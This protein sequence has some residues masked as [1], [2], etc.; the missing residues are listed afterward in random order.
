MLGNEIERVAYVRTGRSLELL[1]IGWNSLEA[2]IA[3]VAGIVAGS[4]ALVGFGLDSV[5]ESLP[6][7][8]CCGDCRWTP[9]LHAVKSWKQSH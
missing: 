5:I 1:A 8:P 4:I 2:I 6:A 7:L 9:I 3:L